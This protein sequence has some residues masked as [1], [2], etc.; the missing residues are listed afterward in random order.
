MCN[1]TAVNRTTIDTSKDLDLIM[2]LHNL[3]EHSSSFVDTTNS[4]WF[5]FKGKKTSFNATI[6]NTYNFN[7]F[8][9]K[10]NILGNTVCEN[11]ILKNA[12]IVVLLKYLSSFWR[13]LE[14]LL[15]NFKTKAPGIFLNQTFLELTDY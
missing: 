10:A 7:P 1:R 3:L 12:T 14:M 6:E 15:I 11:K 8:R 4:L 5:C 2:P 9:Y 13:S